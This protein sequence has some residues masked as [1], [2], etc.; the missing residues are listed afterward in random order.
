MLRDLVRVISDKFRQIT[1]HSNI[2]IGSK[3]LPS[4][5]SY[6]LYTNGKS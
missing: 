3:R 6:R 5:I 1:I 4:T 2:S